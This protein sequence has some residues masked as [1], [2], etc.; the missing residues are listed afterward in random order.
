[1]W[2]TILL[3][4][5]SLAWHCNLRVYY[6]SST[7]SACIQTGIGIHAAHGGVTAPQVT[8]LVRHQRDHVV[9]CACV[10]ALLQSAVGPTSSRE[11]L[12]QAVGHHF[13][14]QV[15]SST[16]MQRVCTSACPYLV[17]PEA[18]NILLGQLE[19]VVDESA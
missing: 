6:I 15:S 1:M 2:A 3:L 19:A 13:L 17:Q 18:T 10:G 12:L 11:Q 4:H 7:A 16:S 5:P 8:C 14:T 9:T